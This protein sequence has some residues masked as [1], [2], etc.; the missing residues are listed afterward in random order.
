M[1]N[2]KINIFEDVLIIGGIS[3]SISMIQSIL[4]IIILSFQ[5]ALILYKGIRNLV[6]LIK[7]K[8]YDKIEETLKDTTEQLEHLSDKTKDGK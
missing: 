1:L 5:I 7:G 6:K 2:N 4:G 8:E 3:I